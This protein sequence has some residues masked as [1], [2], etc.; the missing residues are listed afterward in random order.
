MLFDNDYEIGFSLC[1]VQMVLSLNP[2]KNTDNEI[3][4][5]LQLQVFTNLFKEDK[6]YQLL[7]LETADYYFEKKNEKFYYKIDFLNVRLAGMLFDFDQKIRYAG[8]IRHLLDDVKDMSYYLI[9][10]RNESPFN[11]IKRYQTVGLHQ[12]FKF[13]YIKDT[14]KV[15]ET[16]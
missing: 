6:Q 16:K 1:N 5:A 15:E 3:K 12:R 7:T 8:L 9:E 2:I 4:S 10:N 13:H 11:S 14:K